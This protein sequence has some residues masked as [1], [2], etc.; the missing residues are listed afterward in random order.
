MNKFDW[1]VFGLIGAAQASELVKD[2][3]SNKGFLEQ[4]QFN[5]M[6]RSILVTDSKSLEHIYGED[7]TLWKL[8]KKSLQKFLTQA[9]SLNSEEFYYFMSILKLAKMLQSNK[10][11]LSAIGEHL[12]KLQEKIRAKELNFEEI[13]TE[14]N[15]LYKTSISSLNFRVKVKIRRGMNFDAQQEARMRVLLFAGIRSAMLWRQGGGSV[16][17][18][19]FQRTKIL[20]ELNKISN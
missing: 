20:K 1:Q 14:L 3:L 7:L 4:N 8:G 17:S 13:L 12:Q 6:V 19:L 15:S 9:P 5:A 18:L 10:R 11:V 2:F 16:P